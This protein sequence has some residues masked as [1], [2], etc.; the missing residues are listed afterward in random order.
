MRS[1]TYLASTRFYKLL[2]LGLETT[3]AP[4]SKSHMRRVK[5]KA[6]EQIA[7][8]LGDIQTAIAA[9]DDGDEAPE[10]IGNPDADEQEHQM[11]E[12]TKAST[13]RKQ[14]S[15]IGEGKATTLSKNQRKRALCVYHYSNLASC[16]MDSDRIR[17]MERL[18][19]PLILSNPQFSSN[20]FQ[21]IRTHAQNT[22]AKHV[23][24]TV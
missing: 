10:L 8:G 9:L 20:P 7:N 15:Q 21:T 14:A 5:R 17:E 12:T 13:R 6:K 19:H 24:P 2:T 1:L 23:P 11:D 22:L 18:R 3:N 4:Y 16:L